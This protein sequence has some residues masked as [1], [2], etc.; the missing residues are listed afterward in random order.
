[1]LKRLV[2]SGTFLRRKVTNGLLQ[3]FPGYK[4][5]EPDCL[6]VPFCLSY[7]DLHLHSVHG[8]AEPPDH[9]KPENVDAKNLLQPEKKSPRKLVAAKRKSPT[10]S[11]EQQIIAK[12][13]T[14]PALSCIICKAIFSTQLFLK[15]HMKG[16]HRMSNEKINQ[17]LCKIWM[18]NN[19]TELD[20][21]T[22]TEED[23]KELPPKD[24]EEATPLQNQSF[25]K[26]K[27][28]FGG[29]AEKSDPG[30][31][32]VLNLE[33]PAV[34]NIA[35]NILGS[36]NN[37]LLGSNEQAEEEMVSLEESVKEGREE[38]LKEVKVEEVV[39]KKVEM[40]EEVKVDWVEEVEKRMMSAGSLF[41]CSECKFNDK[42]ENKLVEHV[43]TN[44]LP[45][46]PGYCCPVVQCQAGMTRLPM[47][48]RHLVHHHPTWLAQDSGR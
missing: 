11:S 16:K 23:Q 45:G 42:E 34:L 19:K 31:P 38:R 15:N 1:M 41:H 43:Q 14:L 6:A 7:L 36:I 29:P 44:H 26:E 18:E 5:P 8:K 20:S 46:F 30:G 33:R 25:P 37:F 47:L 10:P 9:L 24:P 2:K 13:K 4:C 40:V 35:E 48:L 17:V 32:A 39:E 22:R 27:S 3:G 21:P 12:V 28:G